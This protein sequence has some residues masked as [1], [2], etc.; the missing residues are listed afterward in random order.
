MLHTMAAAAWPHPA[1]LAVWARLIASC[2]P[3]T[4]SELLIK[5]GAACHAA[6]RGER[7]AAGTAAEGNLPLRDMAAALLE[8]QRGADTGQ[9]AQARGRGPLGAAGSSSQPAPCLFTRQAGSRSAAA[10]TQ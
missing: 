9:L 1:L 2:Q 6:R 4:T 3:E 5:L 7:H 10:N 8:A